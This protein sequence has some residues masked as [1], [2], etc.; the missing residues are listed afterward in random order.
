MNENDF[1]HLNFSL[2]GKG[3]HLEGDLNFKGDTILNCS[4]KGTLTI[5]DK[6]KL[7]L[8][9][10]SHFEGEIYCHDVE[11]FGDFLGTV[12]ASGTLSIRS[13]ANVSGKLNAARMSVFPGAKLNIEGHSEDLTPETSPPT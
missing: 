9:R 2:I 3:T 12:N 10:G 7:T 13:S 4:V 5:T 11:I 8:E 6:G 1:R